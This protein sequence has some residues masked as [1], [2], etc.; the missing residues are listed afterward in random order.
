MI[1]HEMGS[2]IMPNRPRNGMCQRP[3]ST[4][5]WEVS[6]AE[7]GHPAPYSARRFRRAQRQI[8]KRIHAIAV[9]SERGNVGEPRIVYARRTGGRIIRLGRLDAH[10]ERRLNAIDCE[11]RAHHRHVAHA[12][13]GKRRSS[14]GTSMGPCHSLLSKR[15]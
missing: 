12:L 14:S 15:D 10:L 5:K 9:G 4:T 8:G 2:F 1:L 13:A 11:P 3:Q 6:G 7:P